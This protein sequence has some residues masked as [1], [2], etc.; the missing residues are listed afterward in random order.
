MNN[1]IVNYQSKDITGSAV[2]AA[3]NPKQASIA[4]STLGKF[5][6]TPKV[7]NVT[8]IKEI[9]CSF[10]EEPQVLNEE[11]SENVIISEPSEFPDNGQ[12]RS[13]V[14]S[15]TRKRVLQDDPRA[16]K[17]MWVDHIGTDH[18]DQHPGQKVPRRGLLLFVIQNTKNSPL[19]KGCLY[20]ST[21][22]NNIDGLAWE[23]IPIPKGVRYIESSSKIVDLS[24]SQNE[25][26]GS[27]DFYERMLG[28]SHKPKVVYGLYAL[29]KHNRWT[30]LTLLRANSDDTTRH[31]RMSLKGA[32]KLLNKSSS[33]ADSSKVVEMIYRVCGRCPRF[34]RVRN[35][36][37]EF[38]YTKYRLAI[39]T[40]P[41]HKY[42]GV[43]RVQGKT[44]RWTYT[45]GY[46]GIAK[47]VP[48]VP[49]ME[50]CLITKDFTVI[51]KNI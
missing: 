19:E 24:I 6:G 13:F 48:I 3:D 18:Y 15:H 37:T 38:W 32:K 45:G 27:T 51:T 12:K 42:K 35:P 5:N 28:V 22:V 50:Q 39:G 23:R 11:T 36:T 25:Y 1:Y 30:L 9:G 34:T 40:A 31:F 8:E 26:V 10:H 14:P 4:L 46:E 44:I 41:Y 43:K 33:I 2:V 29:N 20:K 7:Y 16:P 21:K 17:T 49:R 47:T